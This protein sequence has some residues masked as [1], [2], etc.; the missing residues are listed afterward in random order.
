M[1]RSSR[2]KGH[3]FERQICKMINQEMESAALPYSVSRD[4]SQYQTKDLGD[5]V[6]I[7]GFTI[8]CK[9]YKEGSHPMKSWWEQVCRAAGKD[10]IPILVYKFDRKP[11]E[12]QFSVLMFN[13]QPAEDYG[14]PLNDYV[15]R[16]D[17][18]SFLYLFV[19]YLKASN[20]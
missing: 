4:L 5:I 16:M 20:G 9:R 14:L 2:T 17:F 6:G 8:E 18:D 11:I 3:G 13:F 19:C 1:S 10:N 7:P 15:C 12:A